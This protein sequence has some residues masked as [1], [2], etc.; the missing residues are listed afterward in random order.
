MKSLSKDNIKQTIKYMMIE[1]NIDTYKE[2]AEKMG[3]NETTLRTR[4]NRNSVKLVD[5]I[6]IAEELNFEVIVK[7]KNEN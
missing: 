1:N 4:I 2:V 6:E 5:F 7:K 3:T